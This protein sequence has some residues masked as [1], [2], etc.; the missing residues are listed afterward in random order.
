MRNQLILSAAVAALVALL[1]TLASRPETDTKPPQG[2]EQAESV[3]RSSSTLRPA[4]PSKQD[5]RTRGASTSREASPEQTAA[6]LK[7]RIEAAARARGWTG[8]GDEAD[9]ALLEMV[10]QLVRDEMTLA[11]EEARERRGQQRAERRAAMVENFAAKHLL[12]AEDQGRLSDLMA[13]EQEEITDLFRQA[14]EDGSWRAARDEAAAVRDETD[15]ALGEILDEEQM[16]SWQ[17][18]REDSRPGHGGR[19]GRRERR[20]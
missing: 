20:P 1:V 12:G 17:E 11:R 10:G 14:R 5:S 7:R 13:Q 9:D 4:E 15:E 6:M 16:D 3:E 2:V 8:D 18:A 19:S